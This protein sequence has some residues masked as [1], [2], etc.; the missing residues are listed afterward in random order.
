VLVARSSSARSLLFLAA[1][2]GCP[3]ARRPHPPAASVS[4]DVTRD[5]GSLRGVA[6]DERAVYSVIAEPTATVVEARAT[7]AKEPI[8]RTELL[9]TAGPVAR[10]GTLLA[11]TLGGTGHVAGVEMR[12]GPGAVLVGLDAKTGAMRFRLGVDSSEWVIIAAIAAAGDDLLIAG[13]FSGTL[14]TGARVVSSGGKHDGFVARITPS[15]EPRWLVRLGGPGGDGIQGVAA[16]GDRIAIA[17]TF[18][19]GADLQGEALTPFDDRSVLADIFVA[20]LDGAGRRKWTASFGGKADDAVAGVAIDS[21]GRIAVAATAQQ[22]IR[23]EGKD[24]VARGPADGLV[25]WYGKD[26]APGAAFLVG[27]LGLD[28]LHT[29]VAVDDRIVIGGFFA[30]T[31]DL[32]GVTLRAEGDDA[33][34]A[35]LDG[36]E[37]VDVFHVA[38]A[39]RE[40]LVGL[41]AVPGGF[42]AGIAHTAGFTLGSVA[43]PAPRGEA[44]AAIA[45]RPVR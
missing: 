4:V 7:G 31:F 34:A 37:V 30:N 1:V 44:G 33:F 41:A 45:I 13:S 18:S 10:A 25:A 22:T 29:I 39:G 43:L 17:G 12:G 11:V 14:R 9:G 19:A 6:A 38:G 35:T 3:A 15:G 40:E 27:G 20:E 36:R 21:R 2:A 32:G 8:W 5:R 24:L 16:R 23:R 28:G 42:C 26:G